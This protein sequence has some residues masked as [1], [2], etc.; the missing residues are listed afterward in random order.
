MDY[1]GKIKLGLDKIDYNLEAGI[2]NNSNTISNRIFL[3]GNN[4][5]DKNISDYGLVLKGKIS[6][7]DLKINLINNENDFKLIAESNYNLSD[8]CKMGLKYEN[9]SGEN[10]KDNQISFLLDANY[11]LD[12][13]KVGLNTE[14]VIYG[15]H[16][17]GNVDAEK[18]GYLV[19]PY[20]ETKLTDSSNS[21]LGLVYQKKELINEF[22]YH[23]EEYE[24]YMELTLKK[25]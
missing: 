5:D 23:K 17:S 9:E 13:T 19:N 8:N 20:I 10:K 12:G 15:E 22:G 24:K 7:I 16:K 4:K 21:R 18:F 6:D 25:N 3:S 2:S 1:K 11:D 14:K